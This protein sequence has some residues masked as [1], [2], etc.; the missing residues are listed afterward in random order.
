VVLGGS[1]NLYRVWWLLLVRYKID[2]WSGGIYIIY[3]VLLGMYS[4][5]RNR[6]AIYKVGGVGDMRHLRGAGVSTG[7]TLDCRSVRTCFPA[8]WGSTAKVHGVAR[9]CTKVFERNGGLK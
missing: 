7:A 4:L 5:D 2:R 9:G 3:M 6:L 8:A 1:C